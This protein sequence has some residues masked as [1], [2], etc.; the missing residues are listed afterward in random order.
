MQHILVFGGDG[1]LGQSLQKVTTTSDKECVYHFF[2]KQ[3][4]NLLNCDSLD[5]L[6]QKYKPTHIVNCAAY[7]GVDKAEEETENAFSIN[8]L[9]AENIASLCKTYDSCLIQISTDFVFA[10]TKAAPLKEIDPTH[11][12]GIYGKS[13]LK[14][15][16]AVKNIGCCYFIVRTGWLYS[17]F[18]NNFLKTMLRLG[19]TKKSLN[20]VSDQVGTPTYAVDLA[21][22]I[23][24]LI[25]HDKKGREI[26][27]FSNDGVAS[28]YDF[29]H[30]IFSQAQLDVKVAPIPT[31]KY[32]T[33]AKR[34][35]YSVLS[36]EKLINDFNYPLSH[37]KDSLRQCLTYLNS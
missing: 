32:P 30:E 35:L 9:G 10:G 18:G 1:Q 22:F 36:K 24:Y 20:V 21:Y 2:G 23:K 31:E 26:Y 17:E 15:E 29:A 4:A 25:A 16:E 7:T 33:L 37:W 11:P 34:P 27:H 13:K 8:C 5:L 12:I 3:E 14:G 28:W 6:F 19:E